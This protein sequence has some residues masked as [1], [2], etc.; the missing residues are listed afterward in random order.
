VVFEQVNQVAQC[1]VVVTIGVGGVVPGETRRAQAADSITVQGPGVQKRRPALR[2]KVFR[3]K[4]G[5]S[6]QTIGANRNPAEL[7][8]FSTADSAI[9]R[10]EER[11]EWGPGSLKPGC[12]K[13][14]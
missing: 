3:Q 4:D 12:G 1:A 13:E 14:R 5:G 9:V 2:T 11:K 10:E 6:L 7:G 8:Q